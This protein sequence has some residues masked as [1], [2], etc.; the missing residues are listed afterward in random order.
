MKREDVL[1][2]FA[3][4]RS[5]GLYPPIGNNAKQANNMVEE[6]LQQYQSVTAE[7]LRMLTPKLLKMTHWPRYFDVDEELK[8]IRRLNTTVT[9]KQKQNTGLGRLALGR[10]LNPGESW[11][12]VLAEKCARHTFPDASE[13]F[14]EM[15]KLEL[16]IQ[17]K[18]DYVCAVCRGKNLKDCPTG[19]HMP[20]LK[21]EPK[22]GLCMPCVDAAQCQKVLIPIPRDDDERREYHGGGG[23]KSAG[24]IIARA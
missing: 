7:E 9:V 17:A 21:V 6:F 1:D 22:S 15:N 13:S 11:T 4:L 24:Q 14:I 5:A 18:F 8:E 3:K 20:F 2:L 10:E 12:M 16:A 19:G 23:F